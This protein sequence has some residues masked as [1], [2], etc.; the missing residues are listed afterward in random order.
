M[1][2]SRLGAWVLF[3]LQFISA[4]LAYEALPAQVP[5]HI[6]FDGTPGNFVPRS[7]W[8]WF[9]LTF[10][11]LAVLILLEV[12]ARVIRR[13]PHLFNFPEKARFLALPESFREPVIEEMVGVLDAAS[14]VTQGV[15]LLVLLQ[16]WLA[17]IG[18]RSTIGIVALPVFTI[19]L[20][21]A[22]LLRMARVSAAVA[23]AERRAG[24]ATR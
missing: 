3:V 24:L 7:P 5:L 1:R 12:L 6:G 18:E 22:L 10:I 19:V 13:R 14:F 4:V 15:F 8:A 11:A 20:V 17:A 16:L 2:V 23:A 9:G 21:P